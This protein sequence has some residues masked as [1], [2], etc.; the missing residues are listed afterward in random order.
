[1]QR[2][3]QVHGE[4]IDRRTGLLIAVWCLHDITIISM[5]KHTKATAG[6]QAAVQII[7]KALPIVHVDYGVV[8]R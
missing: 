3:D 1:M 7:R 2:L 5:L 6:E 4:A 8:S